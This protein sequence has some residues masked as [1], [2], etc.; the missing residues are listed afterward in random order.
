MPSTRK[1]KSKTGTLLKA[2]ITASN[3][4]Q[5]QLAN[6]IGASTAYVSQVVTGQKTPSAE[7]LNVAA[8]ALNL[9]PGETV[10]LNLSLARDHGF[11]IDLKDDDP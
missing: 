4:S 3:S 11:K 8:S 9:S 6:T 1:P 5:S 7:W 10:Q 2:A